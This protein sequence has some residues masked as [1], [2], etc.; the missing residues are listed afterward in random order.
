MSE[1]T[2]H[3]LSVTLHRG[4]D[5]EIYR[6][7]AAPAAPAGLVA[8]PDGAATSGDPGFTYPTILHLATFALPPQR[9]DYGGGALAAMGTTD[10]FLTLFEYTEGG[11]GALF[12]REGVPWPLSG[13]DFS[14]SAVRVPQGNQ[15][16]CQRFFTVNGRSF[17]LYVVL[18]SHTLRALLAARVNAALAGVRID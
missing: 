15:T 4:W 18:G 11:T 6:R 7:D 12:G 9:G 3:G 5:A 17:G 2:A 13:D 16:G 14:P 1:M 8:G 10:L